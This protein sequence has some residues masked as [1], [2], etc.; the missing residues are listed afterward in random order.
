MRIPRLLAI[1]VLI[2]CVR[3]FA[4]DAPVTPPAATQPVE[5]VFLHVNDNHGQ[6]EGTARFGGEARLATAVDDA[7]AKPGP[8]R[9]F[10]THCGDVSSRGDALTQRTEAAA[11]IAI[12]NRLRYDA[13]VPGNGDYYLPLPVLL[14]R[15]AEAKFPT[16]AANVKLKDGGKPLGQPSVILAAGPVRVALFGLCFART[17]IGSGTSIELEARSWRPG[18]SCRNFASRRTWSSP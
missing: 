10:L 9:Y 12:M 5:I 8:A 17:T 18:G 1:V 6:T 7:R 16:L 2:A 15:M 11:N 14:K 3:A 4:A 13:W